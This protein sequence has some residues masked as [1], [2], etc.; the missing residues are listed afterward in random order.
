MRGGRVRDKYCV[1]AILVA[2]EF[3]RTPP[4][5]H[6]LLAIR[7]Y[8]DSRRR[9]GLRSGRCTMRYVLPF[10]A[11]SLL[12]STPC[13]AQPSATGGWNGATAYILSNSPS[14]PKYRCN[15]AVMVTFT[16]GTATPASGVTDPPTGMTN[17]RV[18]T[19]NYNKNVAGVNVTTWQCSEI[20]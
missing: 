6:R 1:T 2:S 17:G 10:A 4:E 20:L 19:L 11:V 18:V 5:L 8:I 12:I 15:Y 13:F 9:L 7:M 14:S 16:D 3:R